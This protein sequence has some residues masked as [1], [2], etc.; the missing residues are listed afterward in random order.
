MRLRVYDGGLSL[1]L[2]NSETCQCL[3]R[4]VWN[5]KSA[6]EVVEIPADVPACELRRLIR[7]LKYQ[8]GVAQV[9]WESHAEDGGIER[10]E[11]TQRRASYVTGSL[12]TARRCR[13]RHHC[14]FNSASLPFFQPPRAADA[15]AGRM[16]GSMARLPASFAGIQ[17]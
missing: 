10:L 17:R 15:E 6:A 3:R 8:S 12:T 2:T 11:M 13:P 14:W 4:Q 16:H 7:V 9:F 5:E 1:W